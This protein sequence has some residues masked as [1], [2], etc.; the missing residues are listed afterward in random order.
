MA[1]FHANRHC[2]FN[3]FAHWICSA[4]FVSNLSPFVVESTAG[5]MNGAVPKTLASISLVAKMNYDP[6]IIFSFDCWGRF[7]LQFLRSHRVWWMELSS[8]ATE[9]NLPQD[10]MYFLYLPF[11][12]ISIC[13]EVRWMRRSPLEHRRPLWLGDLMSHPGALSMDAP[14]CSCIWCRI[15]VH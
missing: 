12:L 8:W 10:L 11:V 4:N 6:L 3:S 1:T 5:W 15:I 7:N 14:P 2:P 13:C 9:V